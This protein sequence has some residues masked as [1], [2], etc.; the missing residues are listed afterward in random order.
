[1]KV[2]CIIPT[3][4]RCG[5]LL[6]AV[7]SVYEQQ[8]TTPEII[9]VDDG[10]VDMTADRLREQYPEVRLV[11]TNGLGPGPA[12]N[13]GAE[14]ATGD[15]LMFL[16]SD[17]LWYPHHVRTLTEMLDRGFQVAYGTTRTMDETNNN[18]FLIPDNGRG[19]TGD[20]FKSLAK[21]CGMV[22]SAV[23]VSRPAFTRADGFGNENLGEDWSFFL[24][25][26][27]RF[28]FGF[29]DTEPIT[30][31]RLHQGSL[32]ARTDNRKLV[33]MLDRIKEILTAESRSDASDIEHLSSV[34]EWTRHKGIEWQNVQDWYIT[35]QQEGII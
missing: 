10:S 18:E 2:S 22:P 24:R 4:D 31:R 30:L 23:A 13:A 6:E 12:R 27:A 34:K 28:D 7:A 26:A 1:M 35:M 16:D 25:L 11:Q 20:C 21:W 14:A 5:M 15:I 17:D 29:A 19:P 9:V 3:K 33:A 32:C 8:G